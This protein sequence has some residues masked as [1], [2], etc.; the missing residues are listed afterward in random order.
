[1]LS[2][3]N[4]LELAVSDDLNL[5][6][7]DSWLGAVRHKFG[8]GSRPTPRSSDHVLKCMLFSSELFAIV[9]KLNPRCRGC[10]LCV[11]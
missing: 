4:D 3:I 10:G 8:V 9:N 7:P 5:Y 6:D 2:V 11:E 1:M